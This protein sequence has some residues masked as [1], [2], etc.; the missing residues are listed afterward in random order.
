VRATSGARAPFCRKGGVRDGTVAAAAHAHHVP[1]RS[2]N[3]EVRSSPTTSENI[4]RRQRVSAV[5]IE[6]LRRGQIFAGY[7]IDGTAGRGGMGVVYRATQIARGRTVALKLLA[8][9]LAEDSALR[10]RFSRE[11]RLLASIEHPHVIEIHEAGVADE[12]PFISMHFVDGHELHA[13]IVG[14]GGL[15]ADRAARIVAQIADGLDAAHA[16]GLVHRDVT[17]ANVLVERRAGREHAFLCDFGLCRTARPSDA[18]THTGAWVGTLDY[19]APEQVAGQAVDARTD[20]YALGCVLFFALTGRAAFV[21][22]SAAEK[23]W[24]HLHADP[25]SASVDPR[26][27]DR[28][29]PD[30]DDV[31][32]RLGR[33]RTRAVLLRPRR[34]TLG[35]PAPHDLPA[36][37]PQR[38][39]Q[40]LRVE[41]ELQPQLTGLSCNLS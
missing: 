17:P 9:D 1:W 8:P 29:E 30:H 15:G 4:Q 21:G 14:E 16:G 5:R 31:Q 38:R 18:L 39:R 6:E 3:P 11:S 12:Q 28:Q 26:L 41:P 13:L 2:R 34:R 23:L 36:A 10:A 35:R 24:A 7:R 33:P 20:V 32:R 27:A 25:P 22:D 37:A 19:V 40:P